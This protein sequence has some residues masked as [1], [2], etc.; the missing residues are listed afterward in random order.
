MQK[1]LWNKNFILLL[2]GSA[3]STLGDL[4][5]SVAIGYWVYEKTG[6]N[7][8]MGIMSSISMFVTMFLSPFSGSI[9]DKLNRKW[10][11][12]G[13]DLLQ[14]VIMLTVGILA[15]T[16]KLNV[17][18]VLIAAFLAALGSVFYSPAASSVMLEITPR[19]DLVRGQSIFSGSSSFINLVGSALSGLMVAFLGV[20]LIVIINGLSNLYSA[21]SEL[22]VT[23]P[24]SINQGEKITVGRIL[25]D[26][27]AAVKM[28][29]SEPCLRIFVP[30]ALILNLLSA[31]AFTLMLPFCLEKS[32]SV[33]SYGYLMSIWTTASLICVVLLGAIK[34]PSKVR[35]WVMAIGFTF[36]EVFLILGYLSKEFIVLAVF[37]FLGALFNTAGNT[38]F[39]ASL[40]LALPEE[41]RNAIL[42]FIQSASVGGT[43]LSAV[44]Y[45]ILG[46]VFPLYIVFAAGSFISLAPML[47]L[48]FHPT[49][50]KFV[51]TH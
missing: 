33:D 23:V 46:D 20:P 49:T 38:V 9:V 28:I 24:K 6:S 27:K 2:Q 32:F 8:L 47:F 17:P 18:L 39:N 26:T 45:G 30:C 4:M 42:G 13:M 36:A 51:L 16:E 29:F 41:N 50:K 12:V 35:F 11:L 44:L 34:L 3:V 43:A 37:A 14:S 48:C 1:K 22:F 15:Y 19:D 21:F 40:M 10:V 31:G 25:T 5:Y 7:S